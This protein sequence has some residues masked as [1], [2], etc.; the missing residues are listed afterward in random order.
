VI[1]VRGREKIIATALLG[2][3]FIFTCII[4]WARPDIFPVSTTTQR[5]HIMASL[6]LSMALIIEAINLSSSPIK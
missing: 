2:V 3:F 6:I 1:E 4:A 5:I